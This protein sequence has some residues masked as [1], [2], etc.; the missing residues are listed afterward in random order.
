MHRRSE[1]L[2]NVM[3]EDWYTQVSRSRSGAL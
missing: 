2:D 3:D 1:D